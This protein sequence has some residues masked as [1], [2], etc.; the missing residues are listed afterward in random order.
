MGRPI[1]AAA[2][3]EGSSSGEAAHRHLFLK[4]QSV[5]TLQLPT[6]R[7]AFPG[8]PWAFVYRDGVE[9]LASL[10]RGGAEG[11]G[12]A[13]RLLSWGAEAVGNAPCLRPYG[14][15]GGASKKTPRP[16]PCR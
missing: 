9:V 3:A 4:L 6:W 8:T 10:L 13:E 12:V 15:R 14:L 11:A 16:R 7:A 2:P 5:L 1:A